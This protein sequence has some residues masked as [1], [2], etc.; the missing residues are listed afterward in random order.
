VCS[1]TIREH[2]P[3]ESLRTYFLNREGDAIER[4]RFFA[5]LQEYLAEHRKGG[6]F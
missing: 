5:P 1:K 3:C 2:L 4:P 6:D